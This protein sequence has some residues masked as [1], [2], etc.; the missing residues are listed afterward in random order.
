MFFSTPGFNVLKGH[1]EAVRG[2][3]KNLHEAFGKTEAEDE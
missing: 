3:K 2:V 1:G